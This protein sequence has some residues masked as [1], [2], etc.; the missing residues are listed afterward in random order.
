MKC[1]IVSAK[2]GVLRLALLLG[3]F[4]GTFEVYAAA[5][6]IKGD[7]PFLKAVAAGI[8]GLSIL[9]A[10]YYL[11]RSKKT[12]EDEKEDEPTDTPG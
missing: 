7:D 1:S 12:P 4:A 10:L 6:T 2:L 3:A 11:I 5:E 8:F 9:G